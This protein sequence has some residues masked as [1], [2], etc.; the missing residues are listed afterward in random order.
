MRKD[1]K[2]KL[3]AGQF[4]FEDFKLGEIVLSV[5]PVTYGLRAQIVEIVNC[6]GNLVNGIGGRCFGIEFIDK[7]KK[8]ASVQYYDVWYLHKLIKQPDLGL[9]CRKIKL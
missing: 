4:R 9:T 6:I 5:Y 1:M 7:S 2:I 3:K 8:F